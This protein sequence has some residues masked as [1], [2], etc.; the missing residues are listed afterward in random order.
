[1]RSFTL[2]CFAL[3]LSAC[4]SS[5]VIINGEK[6]IVEIADSPEERSQGLMFR[7]DLC[8]NCGMFFIFE[9]EGMHGFWMKNT[10]IPLDIMFI[11]GELIIVDII[12]A[13]PCIAEDCDT[14]VPRAQALYVLELNKGHAEEHNFDIGD[15][16]SLTI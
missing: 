6:I 10:L 16:V 8:A 12:S 5:H 9:Q 1:M 13:D 3:F 11:N 15:Q 7:E 2:I 14:Y 4:A